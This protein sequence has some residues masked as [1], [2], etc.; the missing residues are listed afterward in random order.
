MASDC[1]SRINDMML[2][3]S[4]FSGPS[5]SIELQR[6]SSQSSLQLKKQISRTSLHRQQSSQVCM[7]VCLLFVPK[8][9]PY[10]L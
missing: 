1:T 7:C 8:H 6:Q 10:L 3:F 5:D 9:L 2:N 4:N